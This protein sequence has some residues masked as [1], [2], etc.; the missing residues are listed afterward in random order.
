MLIS[1]ESGT[2]TSPRI[3]LVFGSRSTFFTNDGPNASEGKQHNPKGQIPRKEPY[4]HYPI[5]TWLTR[6]PNK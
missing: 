1:C 6:S 2:S 5:H 4:S 3:A